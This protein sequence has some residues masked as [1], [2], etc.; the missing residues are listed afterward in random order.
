MN[1]SSYDRGGNVFSLLIC[2]RGKGVSSGLRTQVFTGTTPLGFWSQVLSGSGEGSTPSPVTG[3]IPGPVGR[4]E[5]LPPSEQEV[6][7][8]LPHQHRGGICPP[9]PPGQ[10]RD[11][12]L[13]QENECCY[14]AG[15]KPLAVT[16]E[17]FLA[18]KLKQ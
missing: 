4:G 7:L 14:A 15:G 16:Q 5:P 17:V 1:D 12:P 8:P 10:D 3:P 11:V 6:P 18:L 9:P 13:G 2:P